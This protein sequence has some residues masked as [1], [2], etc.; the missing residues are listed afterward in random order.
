M[1]MHN[2]GGYY[3]EVM[4]LQRMAALHNRR[5]DQAWIGNSFVTPTLTTPKLRKAWVCGQ[6]A[7]SKIQRNL[8]AR[9]SVRLQRSNK[10]DLR[11]WM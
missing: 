2:N 6:K 5:T 8:K 3:Q 1:V 11:C 4:H 7:P 10:A 9:Y